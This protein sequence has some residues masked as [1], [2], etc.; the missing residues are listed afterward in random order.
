MARAFEGNMKEEVSLF[1]RQSSVGTIRAVPRVLA[2][3][4]CQIALSGMAHLDASPIPEQKGYKQG[5][6][7][8]S[9]EERPTPQCH[10]STLV[11][12]DQGLVAAWFGGTREKHPDVGIWVSRRIEGSMD[13]AN[14][15]S[16]RHSEPFERRFARTLSLLE[17]G[18]VST[19][20]WSFDALFQGRAHPPAMVGRS[21]DL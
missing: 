8:Y 18:S 5:S 21:D 16:Q 19:Q 15:G 3:C 4:L 7:I 2:I 1:E 9:L 13:H 14:G 17:S 11:E 10:A 20:E 6:L 12:G